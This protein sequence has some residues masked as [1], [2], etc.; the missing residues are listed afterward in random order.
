MKN[1]F[2]RTVMYAYP[3]LR[4]VDKD[5]DECIKNRALLS[6]RSGKSAEEL[7]VSIAEDI[8]EKRKLL[9]L[10]GMVEKVLCT[11]SD[12]EKMLVA[13]RYFGKERKKRGIVG[14]K[15]KA[16]RKENEMHRAD[17]PGV[18]SERKYFRVQHR[19][20]ERLRALFIQAGLTEEVFIN[21][22]LSVEMIEKI[23]RFAQEKDGRLSKREM[24]WVDG[25]RI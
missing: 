4:T 10:K 6:Y 1:T 5:Y 20:C 7:S 13:I 16:L 9:W 3:Y 12:A 19:L 23:Y 24:A 25:G 17:K 8:I 22:F 14:A 11:L 21:E 2:V 18:W 15:M